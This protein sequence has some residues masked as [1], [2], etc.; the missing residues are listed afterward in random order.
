VTVSLV[1]I[2]RD[3]E[4]NLARCLDSVRGLFDELIIVDMGSTDRTVEIARSYGARVVHFA[5][6][7]DF[8]AARNAGLDAATRD[9]VAWLDADDLVAPEQYEPFR[10]V[11]A[12][13]SL[14]R[15]TAVA[16][17]CHCPPDAVGHG[18]DTVVDHVRIFPRRPGV[19]WRYRVH[20]QVVPAL[21]E[22]GIPVWFSGVTIIHHGY[23]DPALR[24]RKL[25]R[26]E[27]LLELEAAERPDDPFVQFNLGVLAADRSQWR[28][29]LEHL[30]VSLSGCKPSDSIVRKLYVLIARCH[31]NLA[32]PELALGAC[33]KGLE[34]EPDNAEL[35]F[36]QAVIRF[37]GGDL[38]GAESSWRRIL[39]LQRPDRFCSLDQGI[40]GH[41]TRRNLA[42]LAERQGDRAEAVRQWSEVRAEC[43]GDGQAKAALER[44]AGQS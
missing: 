25:E 41:L 3:E 20:E 22:A 2:V 37:H 16:M 4:A 33:R 11:L 30:R 39:T 36:R 12:G 23:F 8:A 26:D 35:W 43:P 29:A 15:P 34:V 31:E 19:R 32:E 14:D 28:A 5:W 40:Y 24:R 17:L 13:L 38:D 10:A 42:M 9:Y 7:D 21:G 18:G 6:V 44:L 1:M 27:R